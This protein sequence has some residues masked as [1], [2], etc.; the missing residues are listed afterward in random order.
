LIDLPEQD[1]ICLSFEAFEKMKKLRIFIN[2]NACFSEEPSFL[3]NELRL[4]D[5]P[6]YS[7]ESLPSNFHGENLVVFRMRSSCL[8][9]IKGF[10]VQLLLSIFLPS[11][12]VVNLLEANLFPLFLDRTF[13]T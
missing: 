9:G 7:M 12:Y 11:N 6:E 4:L 10:Q 5:W 3:S 13:K 1:L 2:H 8:K